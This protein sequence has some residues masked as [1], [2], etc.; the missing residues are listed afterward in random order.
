MEPFSFIISIGSLAVA[1]ISVYISFRAR[2]LIYRDKLYSNQ[3]E[4]LGKIAEQLRCIDIVVQ[5]YLAQCGFQ[6]NDTTRPG[7]RKEC[8]KAFHS[9]Y[10]IWYRWYIFLP[11]FVIDEFYSYQKTFNAISVPAEVA[12]QY[13]SELVYCNDPGLVMSQSYCKVIN[14]IRKCI[15]VNT[16]SQESINLF[17]KNTED[18]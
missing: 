12:H 9:F 11:Q 2:T 8:K 10:Q 16:L 15:G 3:I 13:S 14:A 7:L 5:D 1:G 6:L 17:G 18:S 4:A